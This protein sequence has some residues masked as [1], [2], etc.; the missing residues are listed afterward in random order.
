[1]ETKKNIVAVDDSGIVLKMLE[2]LLSETYDFHAFNKGMRALKYLKRT[3]PDLIILDIEMPEIDGHEMLRLLKE[4]EELKSVPVIFL[5]SNKS[6]DEVLKAARGGAQD[7]ILKP[8]REEIL[9]EK[10]HSL[11][12]DKKTLSWEDI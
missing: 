8:I 6:R 10:I 4:R 5:T 7:Y 2:K 9:M 3:V 11:F 12:D 1:M